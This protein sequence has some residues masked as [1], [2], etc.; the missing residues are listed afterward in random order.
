MNGDFVVM[1]AEIFMKFD[2]LVIFWF[3]KLNFYQSNQKN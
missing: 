3:W 2:N 1:V